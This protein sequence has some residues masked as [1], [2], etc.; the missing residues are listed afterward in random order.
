MTNG[1]LERL[2]ENWLTR[3]N[4]REY[5]FP[6]CQALVSKGYRVLHL[7]AHGPQEQGKDII[8]IDRTGRPV[9]YQLKT[10]DLDTTAYRAIAGEVAELVELPIRY[11]G[12]RSDGRYRCVLVTN[13][14]LTDPVR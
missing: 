11:P 13:G 3:A 8:A 2:V 7:S 5:Q 12:V 9:G 1:V 4:E 6:F 14:S 10:G